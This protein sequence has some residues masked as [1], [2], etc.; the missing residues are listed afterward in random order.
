MR[1]KEYKLGDVFSVES[2]NKLSIPGKNYI[3][4]KDIIDKNGTVPYIAAISTNNG[5]TGYSS[6]YEAN[7]KGDCITLSTTADSSNTVFYQENAFI[8]RQQIAGIRRKDGQYMGHYIGLYIASIIKK[9]TNSF[10]YS[11][12]LTK[13]FLRNCIIS[14]PVK[15]TLVPD[16]ENPEILAG[17]GTD[18]SNIDTSS[19]KEFKLDEILQK[20]NTIK[21]P[22]KKGE[23]PTI[24]T[25]TYIIPA[26]TA[27]VSNQG[28][29]CYVPVDS[30]TVLKNKI[31]VSANGDFC[32]FWHDSNFTILQD[33]YA[34]EGKGFEL[35]EKIALFLISIMTHSFSQKYNWN[36][37]A[38]WEKL[39][40]ETIKLPVKESEEIDWD[41]MQERIAE[42]EQERI[43]KLEQY[44]IA[45]GLNDYELTDEDKEILATKL[46]DGGVLQSSTSVNGC[47]KEAR[48]FK[49]DELFEK[50]QTK[51]IYGKANDF[52]VCKSVEYT[53]PLLT[54]GADNQGFA[55]YGKRNQC[56]NILKN[57][58]SISANGAN[59]GV[60]F[61]QSD[62]FAVLQD[63]YAIKLKGMEI[64]NKQVGLFLAACINKILHGNFSWTF[65][66]GWERI[67]EMS[68][69]LPI[70]QSGE[71]DWEYM[72]KYIK[73][74][75]K[76]VIRDVVDW[77]DEMIKKTKEVV[78]KT[79]KKDYFK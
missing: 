11:N 16:F 28:L 47:L 70:K 4:D 17:G 29:S 57:V 59:T 35:T 58:I 5:I 60:T 1:Y 27:T 25:V 55:R 46:T 31:S 40:N 12:K 72:E 26:R 66:A 67:K 8:G 10:N 71:I 9:I 15:T 22:L 36:N 56:P 65:K 68:I 77:K 41:Y 78:G 23:C 73:A 13:D 39:R 64:P 69:N 34:L 50:I 45:T 63:A 19:W 18:M 76:V 79:Y 75:E 20:V 2:V 74:T 6:K 33:A 61:Y 30:C 3:M 21:I 43:A 38:G 37:K 24:P 52:P 7:N 49:L 42:L 54:A 44:L 14:L 53:I 51:K 62:E 32:A 48:S